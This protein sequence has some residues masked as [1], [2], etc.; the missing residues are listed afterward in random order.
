M[1]LISCFLYLQLF[2]EIKTE[3]FEKDLYTT[4]QVFYDSKDGTKIPM[5]LVHRKDLKLNSENPC[6]LYGYGGFNISIKPSFSVTMI[7]YIQHVNGILA[8]PN[9]RGGG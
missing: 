8:M 1:K 2:R 6:L 4:K 7:L 3:G 5:F 9:I